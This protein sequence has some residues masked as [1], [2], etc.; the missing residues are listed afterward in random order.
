ML[1]ENYSHSS[2]PLS[3]KINKIYSENKCVC[4][5]EIIMINHNENEDQNEKYP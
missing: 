5:H 2:S 3:S 4:F 1:F